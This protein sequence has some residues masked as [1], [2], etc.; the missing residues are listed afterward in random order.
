[1]A[2]MRIKTYQKNYFIEGDAPTQSTIRRM[3]N[4]GEIYG[5]KKGGVYYVDPDRVVAVNDLVNKVLT[6]AA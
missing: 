1:M 6:N 3:I 5:E 4:D 2:L